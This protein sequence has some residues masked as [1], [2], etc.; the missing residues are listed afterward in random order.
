MRTGNVLARSVL[1]GTR[2][3]AAYFLSPGVAATE[4]L[5]ILKAAGLKTVTV[6]GT[7]GLG[8]VRPTTR[9][10]RVYAAPGEEGGVPYLRPYDVFDYLPQAADMLAPGP[11]SEELK[12]RRGTIL[13]TCSGRNLGPLSYADGFVCDFAVSDDMLRLEIDDERM[14]AYAFTYLATKTGQSLLRRS[15]TG[16]VID[17]LSAA[18]LSSVEVP[19]LDD[20]VIDRIAGLASAAFDARE[21]ARLT[22]RDLIR[23]YEGSLPMPEHARPL[24]DGWSHSSSALAGRLD[25]AFHDPAVEAVRQQLEAV[26]AVRSGDY[27]ELVM[28]GR[29]VR[30]YVEKDHGVPVISGR[31][32]GQYQPINLRYLAPHSL[33]VEDYELEQGWTVFGGEG[34][35]EERLGIPSLVTAERAGWLASEH[36]MRVVPKAGVHAGWLFLAFSTKAVQAQVKSGACGS[37]ID[38]LQ[39]VEMA[40]VLLPPP[41][42]ARGDEAL[43]AWTLFDVA[44][45]LEAQA[46]DAFDAAIGAAEASLKVV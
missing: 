46:R 45:D 38:E 33:P 14:R 17:H 25:A 29:Y 2:L 15:K 30:V 3:D 22:L 8:T 9:S 16:A 13:Q 19:I 23:D 24:R 5:A 34:R 42:E 18:D 36:V 35:A 43:K 37:V 12:P 1:T 32:L 7:H 10:K 27:A 4:R 31:Q 26:G 11:A 28:P 41:D 44:N 6:G 39:P 40:R 21:R 20:Q